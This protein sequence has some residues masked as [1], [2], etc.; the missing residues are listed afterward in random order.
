MYV[1]TFTFGKTRPETLIR[2]LGSKLALLLD[3]RIGVQASGGVASRWMARHGK[4]VLVQGTT[5]RRPLYDGA[6]FTFDATDDCL[7]QTGTIGPLPTTTAT[8]RVYARVDQQALP[9]DTGNRIAFG[10]GAANQS[11]ILQRTVS[12]GVNR[13]VPTTGNGSS[14]I[15]GNAPAVDFSGLQVISGL[16]TSA[17]QQAFVGA[18]AGT[19][20]AVSTSTT[21]AGRVRVGAGTASGAASFWHGRIGPIVVL[22]ADAT[23]EEEALINAFM[24]SA[25]WSS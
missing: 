21:S 8:S 17:A 16:T 2:K 15:T 23:A 1:D 7:E 24:T 3:P 10:W 12:A 14:T 25:P 13:L 22:N 20:S 11:R 18:T 4:L 5:S 6:W 19:S 9:A